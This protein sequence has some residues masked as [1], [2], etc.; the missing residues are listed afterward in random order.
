MTGWMIAIFVAI[1]L[2]ALFAIGAFI[3]ALNHIE[4]GKGFLEYMDEDE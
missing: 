1:F 3:V 2:V 4:L